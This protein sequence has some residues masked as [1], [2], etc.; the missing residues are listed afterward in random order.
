MEALPGHVRHR[1][2]RAVDALAE[3][4]RPKRSSRLEAPEPGCDLR[5]LRIEDWRIIYAV[6]DADRTVDVLA[7]RKR[8]PYRYEDLSDLIAEMLP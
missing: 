4:P 1:V 5:R 8:P 7:V 6:S 3:E 2:K